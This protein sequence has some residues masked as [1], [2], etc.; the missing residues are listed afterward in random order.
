MKK[1]DLQ[2]GYTTVQGR[3]FKIEF[4]TEAYFGLPFVSVSEVVQKEKTFGIF[5]KKKKI[6]DEEIVIGSGWTE[7]SRLQWALNRI[8]EYLEREAEKNKE[9][10]QIQDFCKKNRERS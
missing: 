3:I 2:T 5:F 6:V 4:W 8:D 9:F 1:L 10:E 7:S